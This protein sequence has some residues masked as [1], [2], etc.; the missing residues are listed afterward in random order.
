[1][2]S[3]KIENFCQEHNTEFKKYYDYLNNPFYLAILM[4]CFP[5][6]THE[7]VQNKIKKM[8]SENHKYILERIKTIDIIIHF[9]QQND[10]I[11]KSE[12]GT[13]FTF[14][15][16]NREGID[17][18]H[19][20][21]LFKLFYKL[22]S[23]ERLLSV[24]KECFYIFS[25]YRACI[26][27]MTPSIDFYHTTKKKINEVVEKYKDNIN[28]LN[29]II[30]KIYVGD[31]NPWGSRYYS[32]AYS[33][34]ETLIILQK[35][36]KDPIEKLDLQFIIHKK[37]NSKK[38]IELLCNQYHKM[39][40]ITYEN[41]LSEIKKEK[42]KN[43]SEFLLAM[44]KYGYDLWFTIPLVFNTI[45]ENYEMNGLIES[46]LIDNHKIYYQ[47]MNNQIGLMCYIL[48]SDGM[49]S[50]TNIFQQFND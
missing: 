35:Y 21:D 39:K 36:Y 34:F 33:M 38:T 14:Y 15:L 32:T 18:Y 6:L 1:M 8:I 45:Y 5:L 7:K 26:Y 50:N 31:K 9:Y 43:V 13:F 30:T 28:T 20:D 11:H 25:N 22:I 48:V 23:Y 37:C 3:F 4:K 10:L 49:I 41:D 17:L 44:R 2:T 16:K 42:I 12:I 47:K 27:Y 29:Q 40:L 19:Y 46:V 24:L